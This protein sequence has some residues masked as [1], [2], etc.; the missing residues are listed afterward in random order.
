MTRNGS[1]LDWSYMNQCEF[2]ID[3]FG[4]MGLTRRESDPSRELK[5]RPLQRRPIFL[6]GV[7]V[8]AVASHKFLGV[9]LDQEL[10]GRN[11][12]NM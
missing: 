7:K 3:K 4:V 8:P 12:V 9:M 1:G 10:V 11:T 6:Q 5:T 2:A